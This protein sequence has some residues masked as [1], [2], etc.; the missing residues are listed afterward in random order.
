M[1]RGAALRSAPCDPLRRE[2]DTSRP[3]GR[4]GLSQ[5][6]PL[7][8]F[9]VPNTASRRPRGA[10]SFWGTPALFRLRCIMS[11]F[12]AHP[13]ER[14]AQAQRL[15]ETTTLSQK[16]RGAKGGGGRPPGGPGA[17]RTKGPRRGDAG[18]GGGAPGPRRGG[19]RRGPRAAAAFI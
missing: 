18:R 13:P 3:N 11:S 8:L 6:N 19:G 7:A 15:Y 9:V 1:L 14:F 17:T 4:A 2:G 5:K 16:K 12:P 10:V